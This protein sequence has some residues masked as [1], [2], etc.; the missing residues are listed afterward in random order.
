MRIGIVGYGHWGKILCRCFSEASLEVAFIADIVPERRAEASRSFPGALH[1]SSSAE[2]L[3]RGDIDAV[4]IATPASTHFDIAREALEAG[5]HVWIEKPIAE[6]ADQ[7][8]ALA[9]L[10]QRRG[11]VLFI[12]HTYLYSSSIRLIKQ[13]LARDEFAGRLR[14]ESVRTNDGQPRHDTSIFHD[15]T[16]HDLAILDFLVGE[17]PL[18]V[19]ATRMPAQGASA[20]VDQCIALTYASGVTAGI[21]VN[22]CA[23]TKVRRI[24]ISSSRR[25]VEFD[26]METHHKVRIRESPLAATTEHGLCDS[27]SGRQ[28]GNLLPRQDQRET[29]A[30]AVESFLN[31][32]R[33]GQRPVSDG[34]QGVRLAAIVHACLSSAEA[35]GRWTDVARVVDAV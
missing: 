34:W 29:L 13:M 19:S 10:A 23:S 14:Y 4:A 22:W 18:A 5:K 7:A 25:T 6:T 12:D 30:N 32:I 1:A 3:V 20:S 35:D 16:I 17:N 15:L 8:R 26:D 9:L 11:C 24:A 27:G 33:T 21:R 28:N 2:L 31:S